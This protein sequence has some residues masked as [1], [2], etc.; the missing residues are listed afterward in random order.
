MTNTPI[1]PI[2]L[3]LIGRLR[4][5][6]EAYI[7]PEG[8]LSLIEVEA[9]R[10]L[11]NQTGAVFEG[12]DDG[13]ADNQEP[14]G[15][16]ESELEN[17]SQQPD[18]EA[19][20]KTSGL[21]ADLDL[22]AADFPGPEESDL[23]LCIDFGTAMSKAWA[24]GEEVDKSIP[25]NLGS[26]V[27]EADSFVL[28]STIF[29][30]GSGRIF[31]G[32]AA[33]RQYRQELHSGRQPFDNIKRI[34]SEAEIGQDLNEVP[35]DKTI[36]PTSSGI[37]K[38]DLLLL[39][40]GWL[41]DHALKA[42]HEAVCMEEGEITENE[43]TTL[44]SI[45]RRFAIP[46]FENAIDEISQGEARSVWV[47]A[48]LCD[49][50][51]KAQVIADTFGTQWE[52]LCISDALPLIR[53]THKIKSSQLEHLLAEQS[54][55]REPIAAGAS[56]FDDEISEQDQR[57]RR[58]LL[59]IDAGAG[60]TDFAVFHAF[61][62]PEWND[63]RVRYALISPTVKM[64]R[65][66]GNEVDAI[67]RPLILRAAGINPDNGAPRSESDFSL[68]RNDLNS[69]IREIK[70]LLFAAVEVEYDLR[71]GIR[72]KI[73]IGDVLTDGS[74]KKRCA[75]LIEI[76]RNIVSELFSAKSIEEV[77]QANMRFGK[78]MPIFVLLT[79]GSS[80]VP[81]LEEISSGG[82][83]ID[84]AK[85]EF[86]K[87]KTLPDWI[88][89]SERSFLDRIEKPY[90]QCAV[91]IGGTAPVLPIEIPELMEAVTSGPPG[92]WQV[93]RFQTQGL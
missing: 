78:A 26:T 22:T 75:E 61:V 16:L 46:C 51:L 1:V 87:V 7:L 92:G 45:R 79:G 13:I 74:Y 42:L 15:L 47:K 31:F 77:K 4:R 88:E 65:I 18:A 33:E 60:T 54:T 58:I 32:N 71:P 70:Q 11:T 35:V 24:A 27:G 30:T 44:R 48:V 50:M 34:L 49:A 59:V 29:I 55:V 28:P 19:F 56:R 20:Q 83:D 40:L 73:G 81:M 76:R 10:V 66:A 12:A 14:K 9:L 41:T 80:S 57:S 91:A 43:V 90:P 17:I 72:G 21:D 23:R 8:R 89:K 39:Y 37:T 53:T 85:F 6:G 68:I 36:D 5:D 63:Q 2:V 86:F 82:L 84:G 25:L 62:D 69:Q 3:S 64:S 93:K 67:L 52:E 38:G